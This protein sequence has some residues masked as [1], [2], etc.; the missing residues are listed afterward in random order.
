MMLHLTRLP[1][2][3][4]VMPPQGLLSTETIATG[5]FAVAWNAFV[6]FWTISALA[7]GGLVVFD[8]PS[9]DLLI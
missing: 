6:A 7:G 8:V 9:Y 2:L 5:G 3:A 1:V 4:N